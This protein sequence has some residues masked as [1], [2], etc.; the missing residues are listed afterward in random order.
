MS[1]NASALKI[2]RNRAMNSPKYILLIFIIYLF[3]PLQTMSSGTVAVLAAPKRGGLHPSYGVYLG[4]VKL[5]DSYK[6]M[7]PKGTSLFRFYTQRRHEKSLAKSRTI[8]VTLAIRLLL[9][10]LTAAW[11]LPMEISP[12]SERNVSS[13]FSSVV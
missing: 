1:P 13:K 11:N 7:V 12:R 4:G 10:S 6:C 5:D 3:L 2:Q 9:S 8:Y